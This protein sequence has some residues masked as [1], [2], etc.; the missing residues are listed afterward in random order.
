MEKQFK[1]K[2]EKN[3]KWRELKR[4]IKNIRKRIRTIKM[5]RII[6]EIRECRVSDTSRYWKLMKELGGCCKGGSKIPATVVDGAGV[7]KV[8][9]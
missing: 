8:R 1:E 6:K 2:G 7:E 9:G 4:Q 3:M 5:E